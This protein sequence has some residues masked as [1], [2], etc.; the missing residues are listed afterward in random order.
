M[1]VECCFSDDENVESCVVHTHAHTHTYTYVY[2]R[3]TRGTP[4][5]Q[6]TRR[7]QRTLGTPGTPGTLV[8][9]NHYG[10]AQIMQADVSFL[11]T[12]TVAKGSRGP[13]WAVT[14]TA[15]VRHWSSYSQL[16]KTLLTEAWSPP[17]NGAFASPTLLFSFQLERSGREEFHQ[18]LL[19]AIKLCERIHNHS[20]MFHPSQVDS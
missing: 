8:T 13:F 1:H 4:G 10:S 3:L 5:T 9:T 14:A 18:R 16:P 19:V 2:I 6:G 20:L 15:E 11:C 17:L 7:T 12:P